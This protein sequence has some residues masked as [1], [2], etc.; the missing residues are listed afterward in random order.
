MLSCCSPSMLGLF[1]KKTEKERLQDKY[2]KL[3]EVSYKLSH[4]DRM[5]SDK[6]AA[7][8]DELLKKIEAL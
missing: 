6:K 7:E 4:S 8:A 2:K 3:L 1:K 5:A